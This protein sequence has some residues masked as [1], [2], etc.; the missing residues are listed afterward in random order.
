MPCG[1]AQYVINFTTGPSQEDVD[2]HWKSNGRAEME[3][4]SRS[5][6][7]SDSELAKRSHLEM[8]LCLANL[9]GRHTILCGAACTAACTGAGELCRLNVLI[10]VFRNQKSLGWRWLVKVRV[11]IMSAFV[12]W[13]M[14]C[15]KS[16]C[17]SFFHIFCLQDSSLLRCCM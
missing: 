5:F 3:V 10:K 2:S 1:Q 14:M 8:L 6:R 16:S 11:C 17:R 7:V 4:R 12:L 13:R 15:R 9:S